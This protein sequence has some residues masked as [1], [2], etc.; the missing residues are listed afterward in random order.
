MIKIAKLIDST[1][2]NISNIIGFIGLL[3]DDKRLK[4]YY[5]NTRPKYFTTSKIE[6]IYTKKNKLLGETTIYQTS[7]NSYEFIFGDGINRF[8]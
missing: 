7:N 6:N 1:N 4:F 2:D 5:S 3:D 8:L